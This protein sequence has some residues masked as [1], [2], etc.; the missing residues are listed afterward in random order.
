MPVWLPKLVAN[1]V[2]KILLCCTETNLLFNILLAVHHS[3]AALW[4]LRD[5]RFMQFIRN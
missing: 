2:N 3:I 4:S 1:K 5:A